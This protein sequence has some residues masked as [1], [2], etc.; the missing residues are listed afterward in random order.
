MYLSWA[1]S[2]GA[3]IRGREGGPE[4]DA[5]PRIFATAQFPIKQL[6]FRNKP[7]TLQVATS[8]KLIDRLFSNS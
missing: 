2:P 1:A 4:S 5:V 8:R 3:E 7:K 6:H